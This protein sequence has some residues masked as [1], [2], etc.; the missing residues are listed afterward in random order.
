MRDDD[1]TQKNACPPFN[2]NTSENINVNKVNREEPTN[3]N[4]A[5]S[6]STSYEIL[7]E[8]KNVDM[9]LTN[10]IFICKT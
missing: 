1:S 2:Q 10:I 7:Q 8:I 3:K 9:N 6:D 5:W 4:R